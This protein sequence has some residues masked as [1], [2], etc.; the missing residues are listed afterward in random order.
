MKVNQCLGM[1]E[2]TV[3]CHVHDSVEQFKHQ[4]YP[5]YS[6]KHFTLSHKG[7]ELHDSMTL[8]SIYNPEE[9]LVLDVHS[10]TGIAKHKDQNWKEPVSLRGQ[11]LSNGRIKEV[12]K[13]QIYAA[14][15]IHTSNFGI[16]NKA[17][18]T[19]F[20]PNILDSEIITPNFNMTV[21]DEN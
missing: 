1:A 21:K 12:I 2:K 3:K 4:A 5:E 16:Y 11:E 7:N 9:I 8:A 20:W 6:E 19:L 14:R 13:G 18:Q 17:I 15:G 10:I